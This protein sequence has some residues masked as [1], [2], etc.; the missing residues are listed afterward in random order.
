MEVSN[1]VALLKNKS[2]VPR[3]F[4]WKSSQCQISWKSVQE[5]RRWYKRTHGRTRQS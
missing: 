4:S 3:Q 5:Q 2:G 1:I